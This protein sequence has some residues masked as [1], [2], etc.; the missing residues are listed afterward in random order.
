MATVVA[1]GM[2]GK[3]DSALKHY[4]IKGMKW[5]VR[6]D[7]RAQKR[8]KKKELKELAKGKGQA[9]ED[10]MKARA[11]E[12]KSLSSLSN[13]EIRVL[14]NRLDLERKYR[15]SMAMSSKAKR[16][17]KKAKS[18]LDTADVIDRSI[19]FLDSPTGKLLAGKGLDAARKKK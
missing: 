12:K 13:D 6:N 19:K 4:G 18:F 3:V 14:T 1:D 11:L 5:G 16:V 8:A 2:R 9:H 17:E 10:Y 15:D 7:R